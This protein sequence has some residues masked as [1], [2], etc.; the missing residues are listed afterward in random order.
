MKNLLISITIYIS[1]IA[2]MIADEFYEIQYAGNLAMFI[3]WF[4]IVIGFIAITT[5]PEEL[6]KN[7]PSLIWLQRSFQY[8]MIGV[9]IMIGWTVTGLFYFLAASAFHFKYA[10]YLEKRISEK[11][12][13]E[14]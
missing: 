4:Y 3:A 6:F 11:K 9:M 13:N 12:E 10:I 5:N 8:L 14:S 2:M 1:M 7:T